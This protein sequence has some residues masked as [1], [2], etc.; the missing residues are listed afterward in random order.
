MRIEQEK[1]ESPYR[2]PCTYGRKIIG[3]V[4]S[5]EVWRKD[6]LSL[7]GFLPHTTYKTY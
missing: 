7:N 6:G 2:D 3:E 1:E 4:G 5:A